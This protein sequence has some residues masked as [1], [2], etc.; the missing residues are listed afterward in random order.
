MAAVTA[1]CLLA[2]AGGALDAWA[3]IGH[4]HVF[5]NAQTGNVVLA[6][7]ALATGDVA[8]AA[9]HAPSFLAFCAG[10]TVSRWAGAVLKQGRLNSRT[11]RLVCEAVALAVLALVAKRL[12]N[13]TVT[14]LVGF[15]AALQITALSHIGGWSFNTGMTTGNLRGAV[16][17][18]V[19]AALD[20]KNGEQR[21]RAIVLGLMCLCFAT[22]ATAEAA[23]TFRW[24]DPA[25]LAAAGTVLAAALVAWT[26]PDPVP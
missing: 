4:G 14:A 19:A 21:R 15:L 7:V 18:A 2:V 11:V 20:R 17:A 10:L 1:A 23:A 8:E 24:G 9:R 25:L 26:V 5:A 22:G 12:A 13:G 16:S 3:Y 6:A